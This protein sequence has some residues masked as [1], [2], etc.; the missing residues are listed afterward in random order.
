MEMRKYY[1]GFSLIVLAGINAGIFYLGYYVTDKININTAIE[2]LRDSIE[3]IVIDQLKSKFLEKVGEPWD[4][5]DDKLDK[6]DKIEKIM[7][8]GIKIRFEFLPPEIK[9]IKSSIF[10]LFKAL[11]FKK[12]NEDAKIIQFINFIY[13]MGIVGLSLIFGL[14]ALFSGICKILD[15]IF[16]YFLHTLIFI[17]LIEIVVCY[18]VKIGFQIKLLVSY[19]K[20]SKI[21]FYVEIIN[22]CDLKAIFIEF[23]K[24]IF[25]IKRY[26]I[27]DILNRLLDIFLFF[28]ICLI[29]YSS[30]LY[31]NK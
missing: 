13:G 23:F 31:S 24:F 29:L 7:C 26:I 25:T 11:N 14:C 15:K 4:D 6:I 20:S 19:N 10:L 9:N 16:S 12:I 27:W 18:F 22:K 30:N 21:K 28:N 17:V 8:F 3:D 5:I 2:N 1:I